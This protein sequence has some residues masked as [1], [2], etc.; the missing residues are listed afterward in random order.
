MFN[1]PAYLFKAYLVMFV[2]YTYWQFVELTLVL[3]VKDP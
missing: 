2:T 1:T 3:K